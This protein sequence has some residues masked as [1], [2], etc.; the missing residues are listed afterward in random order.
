VFKDRL[1]IYREGAIFTSIPVRQITDAPPGVNHVPFLLG[2]PDVDSRALI[3]RFIFRWD[4]SAFKTWLGHLDLELRQ[5]S[6]GADVASCVLDTIDRFDSE[7]RV[8]SL[9]AP[10]A[11][12]KKVLLTEE[13]AKRM[14]EWMKFPLKHRVFKLPEEDRRARISSFVLDKR[15]KRASR[16]DEV[17]STC[18]DRQFRNV[19]WARYVPESR[20][21]K[22]CECQLLMLI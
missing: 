9:H 20:S 19:F 8:I 22:L 15:W 1:E 16:R 7:T 18:V 12:D 3:S 6:R 11:D 14:F 4:L 17:F 21:L 2:R 10:R 5:T 13:T